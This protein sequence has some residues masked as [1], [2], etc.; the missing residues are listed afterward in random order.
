MTLLALYEHGL[1]NYRSCQCKSHDPNTLSVIISFFRE[2]LSPY[3][4]VCYTNTRSVWHCPAFSN[5]CI[6]LRYSELFVLVPCC[7]RGML[8][9]I[10]KFLLLDGSPVQ[11]CLCTWPSTSLLYFCNNQVVDLTLCSLLYTLLSASSSIYL[12]LFP[13]DSHCILYQHF[14]CSVVTSSC[15]P[16]F[17][18]WFCCCCL[19]LSFKSSAL[20]AMCSMN[21]SNASGLEV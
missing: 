11:S 2:F 18:G 21:V 4:S 5:L 19:F 15:Q 17:S 10:M 20:N 12:F 3:P 14:V 13:W 1:R 9:Y 8:G 7:S 16:A 6:M